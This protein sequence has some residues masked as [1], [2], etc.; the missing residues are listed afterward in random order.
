MT[1]PMVAGSGL[2][3]RQGLAAA[4]DSMDVRNGIW[5]VSSFSSLPND[6][7]GHPESPTRA[8]FM[9][10]PVLTAIFRSHKQEPLIGF[11]RCLHYSR[12]LQRRSRL[13]SGAPAFQETYDGSQRPDDS[14]SAQSSCRPHPLA[15]RRWR[16][17]MRRPAERRRPA[18]DRRLPCRRS[19]RKKPRY[20]AGRTHAT[21]RMR[22]GSS[23]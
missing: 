18:G 19:R 9:S 16:R 20:T 23:T 8:V 10:R 6:I 12:A 13:T 14:R 7:E 17:P 22:R 3:E 21:T 2:H 5:V 1:A 15:S 11:C 4:T